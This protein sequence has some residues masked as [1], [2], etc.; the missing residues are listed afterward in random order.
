MRVFS[1]AL[2]LL[3]LAMP[4]LAMPT[5]AMASDEGEADAQPAPVTAEVEA[6]A[7]P[8]VIDNPEFRTTLEL[9]KNGDPEA[10]FVVALRLLEEDHDHFNGDAFGWALNAA[11]AGHPESAELTGKLYRLG[12][13][14][15]RNFVK[16][17]KW[18]FRAI[19]RNATG[20]YFELALLFNDEDN[21]SFNPEEASLHMNSA[22]AKNEPR[23]CL[24]SANNKIGQGRPIRNAL[25]EL[26]CAANGGITSAMIMIAEYYLDKRSPNAEFYARQWLRRAA[27]A[28]DQNAI[29]RLNKLDQ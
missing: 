16:S 2:L 21:P 18:L 27:D 11:R 13:G 28:G 17:R 24:V 29:D 10:M 12:I 9:A 1:S 19:S 15:E 23:A 26:T 22:L 25:K 7:R 5:V 14:V 6:P 4:A 20:A 3:A 8:K